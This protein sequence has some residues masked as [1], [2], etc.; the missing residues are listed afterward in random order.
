LPNSQKKGAS[1]YLQEEGYFKLHK[2]MTKRGVGPLQ[3]EKH[4]PPK[5][6]YQ[7]HKTWSLNTKPPKPN[8]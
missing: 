5:L 4:T 8:S 3:L 1:L 7:K 6:V 2:G